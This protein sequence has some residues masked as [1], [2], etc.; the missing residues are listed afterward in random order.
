MESLPRRRVRRGAPVPVWRQ[1]EIDL[2]FEIRTGFW[3]PGDRL[4]SEAELAA[5][6][7][8][9]RHTVRVALARLAE[10]GL[11]VS[12]QGKG[13]FVARRPVEYAV[14]RESKWSEFEQRLAANPDG[15]LLRSS[16]RTANAELAGLLAL[17]PGAEL[18]V[19]ETLRRAGPGVSAYCYHVFDNARFAGIDA[20]FRRLHS[21]TP[22]LAEFG[23]PEFFRA[24]TWIDCRL[25]RADEARALAVAA[26]TPV[27]V[28]SYVDAG[29]DGT[30]IL[31]GAAVV[32]NGRLRFRIDSP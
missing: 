30:P 19:V 21:Y 8:V 32:P 12:H 26:D 1:I 28:M 20:A 18:L 29:R 23:H 17:A 11:V 6:Y 31:F 22:A 24:K 7:G 25:P 14:T 5:A 27:M 4:P 16:V 13:V 9:H 2:T 15:K 3:G 10:E